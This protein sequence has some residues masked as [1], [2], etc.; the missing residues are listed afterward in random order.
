MNFIER[1]LQALAFQKRVGNLKAG[2]HPQPQN[3]IAHVILGCLTPAG[4]SANGKG[5]K[6]LFPAFCQNLRELG[7]ATHICTSHR[8]IEHRIDKAKVAILINIFGEDHNDIASPQMIHLE[9]KTAAV[10]NRAKMG[11]IIADKQRS[12]EHFT[13][14]GVP[15][16]P[17]PSADGVTFS[18]ARTGTARTVSLVSGT[19]ELDEGRYNRAM[20]NTVQTFEGRSY[21]T[22]VRLMCVADQIVHAMV[23]ARTVEDENPSVHSKNTPLDPKLLGH[24]QQ[25]LVDD[26]QETLQQIARSMNDAIGPCFVAHDILFD[27]HS[28]DAFVCEA[29]LKF[30]DQTFQ[31]HILPI[32]KSVPFHELLV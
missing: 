21:H 7:F 15:M 20:I 23:R 31:K 14:F 30:F 11:T 25:K 8:Q 13:K 3:P 10:F 19:Q 9:N 2:G 4:L 22:T 26:Q 5:S 1:R 6:Q 17:K 28:R 24:L 16:P 12:L 29:G 27:E 32:G 18:N